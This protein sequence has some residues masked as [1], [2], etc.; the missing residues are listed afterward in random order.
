M[1][2]RSAIGTQPT[3][4]SKSTSGWLL[5]TV[6]HVAWV[7]RAWWSRS[8]RVMFVP[9]LQVAAEDPV[10]S[11][12]WL[13]S[14]KLSLLL[15]SSF[16]LSLASLC[17]ISGYSLTSFTFLKVKHAKYDFHIFCM[18]HVIIYITELP[19][20]CAL[21]F[22]SCRAWGLLRDTFAN[23]CTLEGGQATKVQECVVT[24]ML[25]SPYYQPLLILTIVLQMAQRTN[26]FLAVFLMAHITAGIHPMFV[27]TAIRPSQVA[28]C[29][30]LKPRPALFGKREMI[31]LCKWF[32][33]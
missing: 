17:F 3:R 4:L 5:R 6:P 29:A 1:C 33:R 30:D 27:R 14:F 32:Q 9:I 15:I 25:V 22:S 16:Y 24:S 11:H 13:L 18:W 31:L 10:C 12:T 8:P 28:N 23:R 21:C 2:G 7:S 20:S 26:Q 19:T